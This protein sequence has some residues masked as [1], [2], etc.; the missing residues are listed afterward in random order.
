MFLK[1]RGRTTSRIGKS[2]R[3]AASV[4]ARMPPESLGL[5]AQHLLKLFGEGLKIRLVDGQRR[6]Q[7]Q[8]GSVGK[9]QNEAPLHER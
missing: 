5:L 8:R 6:K 3:K 2:A 1:R 7:A 4:Q 9:I